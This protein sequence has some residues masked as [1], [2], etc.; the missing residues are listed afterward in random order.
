MKFVQ[1]L[2]MNNRIDKLFFSTFILSFTIPFILDLYFPNKTLNML[3]GG[4]SAV[5][6]VMVTTSILKQFNKNKK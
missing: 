5:I 2:K 1:M 4:I 6:I 3:V